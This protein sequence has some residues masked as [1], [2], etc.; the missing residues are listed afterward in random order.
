M[1]QSPRERRFWIIRTFLLPPILLLL[2]LLVRTYRYSSADRKRMGRVARKSVP[3]LATLHGQVFGICSISKYFRRSG[4][5]L[6]VMTSPSKD[7]EVLDDILGAFGLEVVKGSSKSKA[8]AGSLALIRTLRNG[9]GGVLAV[10]GPRGPIGVPK[11]GFIRITSAARGEVYCISFSCRRYL[12]FKS[13]D[14]LYIPA[15]FSR[16]TVRLTPLRKVIDLSEPEDRVQAELQRLLR[17]DAKAIRSPLA[18]W[19][20]KTP[21]R[22]IT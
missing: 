15:P 9:V 6:C 7:G 11:A 5:K 16:M 1:L 4:R 21:K 17:R 18:P 19:I 20:P 2:K 3:I 10:D 12:Q 14:R 8:V 13:W 22:V